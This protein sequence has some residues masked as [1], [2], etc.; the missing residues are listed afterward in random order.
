M[1]LL[2]IALAAAAADALTWWAE[3]PD[4]AEDI[5]AAL[6]ATWPDAPIQVTTQPPP[7]GAGGVFWHADGLELIAGEQR[8]QH[9]GAL[10]AYAAAALT[11]SWSRSIETPAPVLEPE[12]LTP[13]APQPPPEPDDDDGLAWSF[14]AGPATRRPQP[15]PA[16]HFAGQIFTDHFFVSAELDP[17][18][19]VVLWSADGDRQGGLM[20]RRLGATVGVHHQ[21]LLSSGRLLEAGLSV[22]ARVHLLADISTPFVH[23]ALLR[24]TASV[25][26]R[27]W[28]PPVE[29][30]RF[31]LGG[32]LMLSMDGVRLERVAPTAMYGELR[33]LTIAVEIGVLRS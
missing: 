10:D 19:R 13:R 23:N 12:A 16:F 6:E 3:D 8:R 28:A 4:Q 9:S 2:L 29:P 31:R 22:G 21:H 26:V 11:R 33:P 1:W 20:V 7:V 5:R 30:Q 27:V 15:G 25:R 24:P 14:T 32:G 17:A 18:E